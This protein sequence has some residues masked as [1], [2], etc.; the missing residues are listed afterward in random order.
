M[1]AE[2]GKLSERPRNGLD[3]EAEMVGDILP[4]HRK[5]DLVLRQKLRAI[6]RRKAA[7]RS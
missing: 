3:G 4:R 2:I 1:V 7:M 6:S 5:I